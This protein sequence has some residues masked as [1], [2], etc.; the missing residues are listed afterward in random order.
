MVREVAVLRKVFKRP[1][2]KLCSLGLGDSSTTET[3]G[4]LG[5][6]NVVTVDAGVL[7]GRRWGAAGPQGC[8]CALH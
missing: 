8:L 3:T 2:I 4:R 5:I 7:Q 1:W 6:E